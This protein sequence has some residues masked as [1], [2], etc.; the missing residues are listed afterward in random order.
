MADVKLEARIRWHSLKWFPFIKWP[1]AHEVDFGTF[2]VE[3]DLEKGLA[4]IVHRDGRREYLAHYPATAAKVGIPGIRGEIIGR[5]HR[6]NVSAQSEGKCLNIS[7]IS[8]E[9]MTTCKVHHGE[10]HHFSEFS[11]LSIMPSSEGE[12]VYLVVH[13]EEHLREIAILTACLLVFSR[14]PHIQRDETVS[15]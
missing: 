14:F 5:E 11:G 13:S 12:N 9:L 10:F 7:T 2:V 15:D 8:G 6:V 1:S 4:E 3:F